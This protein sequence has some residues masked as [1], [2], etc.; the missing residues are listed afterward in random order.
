MITH[1][2]E[3]AAHARRVVRLVDGQIISD[4]RQRP[5]PDLTATDSMMAEAAR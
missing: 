1:E 3:V 2:D 5:L 4:V